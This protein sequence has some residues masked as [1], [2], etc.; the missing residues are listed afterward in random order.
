MKMSRFIE[1]VTKESAWGVRALDLL[2]LSP[3]SSVTWS[4]ATLLP[5]SL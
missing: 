4:K 1:Q 5:L 2:M 3:V